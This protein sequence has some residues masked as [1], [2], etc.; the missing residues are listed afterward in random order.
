MFHR[1]VYL[2]D[3]CPEAITAV[4]A[5]TTLL[6]KAEDDPRDPRTPN[7][8]TQWSADV[9]LALNVKLALAT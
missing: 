9:K 5:L 6:G 3:V 4:G 8:Q 7:A 1:L 2:S